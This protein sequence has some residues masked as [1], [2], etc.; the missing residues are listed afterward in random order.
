VAVPSD[1]SGLRLWLRA[2][3]ITGL[4]DGDPIAAWSD[5]SGNA[6]NFA[7]AT[8]A[9]KPLYKAGIVNGHAAARF[10]GADDF[11]S[12]PSWA[13]VINTTGGGIY[14][15]M[16]VVS[17][18]SAAAGAA[19][20][21]DDAPVICDSSG[22]AG[23]AF[24]RDI[25]GVLNERAYNWDGTEDFVTLTATYGAWQQYAADH[26]NT[27]L[28]AER[29]NGTLTTIAS[30]VT[31][32]PTTMLLGSN[33]LGAKFLAADVAELIAFNRVL[34]DAERVSMHDYF[35][36]LYVA[37]VAAVE[38]GV[39]TNRG[40]SI[41][42]PGAGPRGLVERRYAEEPAGAPVPL[43]DTDSGAGTDT[44]SVQA[45]VPGSDTG[46]GTET[47][48]VSATASSTD[49]ST[50][51]DA[52][53]VS[54][55]LSS[56]DSATG[57]ESDSVAQ[58]TSGSDSGSGTESAS[59]SVTAS[60]ADSAAGTDAQVVAET[61]AGGDSG[62]GFDSGALSV[63]AS[64]ADTGSGSDQAAA[65]VTAAGADSAV[66]TDS[67]TVTDVGAT[68]VSGSE[69]ATGTEAGTVL[70]L[71]PPAPPDVGGGGRYEPGGDETAIYGEFVRL[72]DGDGGVGWDQG[73]VVD[74]TPAPRLPRLRLPRRER[75]TV[76]LGPRAADDQDEAAAFEAATLSVQ[77]GSE[78]RGMGTEGSRVVDVTVAL[79]REEQEMWAVLSLS[80]V[81]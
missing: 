42:Q 15:I 64:S 29:D 73:T 32:A 13:T 5:T 35:T 39:R 21:Y 78:D 53:T 70:D 27:T 38:Q 4:V 22:N 24:V 34:T 26:D 49:T 33:Y 9:K 48:A 57:T 58:P 51:T 44:E 74:L 36:G 60:G 10:D 71:T 56:S 52:G 65:T 62:A 2:D 67:G 20:T 12:G 75:R 77:T 66:A 61:S 68:Q 47:S 80:G 25:S 76:D 63:A 6:F 55:T 81:V 40:P 46:A 23:V 28:R 18:A 72:S 8:A 79:A 17:V 50:G 59:V 14:T 7:Q 69:S 31:S 16:A 3:D 11:L 30:G 43:S 37:S 1:L 54:A 19:N 41:R 45:S